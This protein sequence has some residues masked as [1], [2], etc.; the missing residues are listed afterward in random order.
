MTIS[1]EEVEIRN[2]LDKEKML[3]GN[4]HVKMVIIYQ[5]LMNGED[6][7]KHDIL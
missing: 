1:G 7:S 4:D 6:Y 5:V 3:I 2:L